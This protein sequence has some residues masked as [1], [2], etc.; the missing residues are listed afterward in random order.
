MPL[1]Y[2]RPGDFDLSDVILTSYKSFDGDGTPKR[3]NIRNLITEFNIYESIDRHFL[4]GDITLT[5]ATNAVQEL[6]ITGFERIELYFRSPGMTKGFD[7]SV[8]SGHPMFCYALLNRQELNPRSQA[9]TIK[10]C[11]LEALRDKQTRVSQAFAGSVDQFLVDI[12]KNYLETKKDILVEETKDMNKVVIPRVRPSTAISYLKTNARSKH[13]VNSGFLCYETS[14][15]FNFKS[16]EGLF[17]KTDGTPREVKARISPKPKNVSVKG[18]PAHEQHEATSVESFN[19]INQFNTLANTNS[20]TYASRL[21][22]H[23]LYNKTFNEIDFDYNNEYGKQNHLEQ[24]ANGN[25]RDDNGILPF[26]NY[27]KGDTFGTKNEG[28][29]LYQSDTKFIHNNYEQPEVKEILQRRISQRQALNS[30]V[31]EVTMP[32]NTELQ[33]GDL[34]HFSLPKY[35]QATT[36]TEEN[37]RYLTGRYL[38]RAARHHVSSINKR[39]TLV[40]ELVKDSFNVGYPD[41]TLDLFTNNELDDGLVFISSQLDEN[42]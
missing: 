3:L 27:D 24:D 17:C 34:V 4:T 19:I 38:I 1:L 39:H 25:K 42:L 15:G 14:T 29:I 33:A 28:M 32:G 5:D 40:L 16:Y 12:F 35:A 23:D 37:D 20:G 18:D 8:K 10:F 2:N 41:E 31:I 36:I 26:F 6:P 9:Y 21:I 11:S 30:L 7:F 13:F 22:V